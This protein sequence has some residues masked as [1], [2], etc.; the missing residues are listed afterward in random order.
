M[1][2]ALDVLNA[3]R[4]EIGFVEGPNNDSKYGKWYG[5]NHNPYCAMFVSWCF[6]E[7]GMSS[8]VAASSKKGFASCSSGLAWFQKNKQIVNKYAGQPGDIVFF[9]FEGNGTADHVG[10]IEGASKEG[11]TTIEANTSP[12]HFN[13]SQ[14]NGGGVYRR[15]RPYLNV[16]AIVRPKYLVATKPA[17]SLGQNKKL[18]SGVAGATALGGGG[19]AMLN[20]NSKSTTTTGTT[21]S[22]PAFPGTNSFKIGAKNKAVFV[23]ESGLVK[24]KLLTLADSTFNAATKSAVL[25][26]QKTN[27]ALGK[28]DGIVGPKTYAA[29]VKEA[30][31]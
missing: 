20:D 3:A 16:M 9:S 18:A 26:Y 2:S 23:I 28:P 15:H 13:G 10:I 29:L 7:A 17:S 31:K 4:G 27:P 6:N 14:R 5:L 12:D 21:I 22:A 8:L 25:K 1:S 19:A 11:I 30:K 24:L